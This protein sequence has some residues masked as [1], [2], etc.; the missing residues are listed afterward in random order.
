MLG[1]SPVGKINSGQC[2]HSD[3]SLKCQTIA[4]VSPS[5]QSSIQ[6]SSLLNA[7]LIQPW[8]RR[9]NGD[10]TGAAQPGNL[11]LFSR[12]G[13]STVWKATETKLEVFHGHEPLP[14]Q[15]SP[16][17]SVYLLLAIVRV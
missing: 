5:K 10:L 12:A 7:T 3:Y 2:V 17:T 13:S 8:L 1:E 16:L 14:Q 11:V 6:L 9:R 4:A 15:Q